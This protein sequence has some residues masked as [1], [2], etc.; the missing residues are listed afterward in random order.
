EVLP[1][2][3]HA[4]GAVRTSERLLQT[5]EI[6]DIGAN[7]F[8]ALCRQCLRGVFGGIAC[9]GAAREPS[10]GIRQ[11]CARQRATLRAGG[12]GDSNDLCV[13]HSKTSS[14]ELV[15]CE[16]S[17]VT[18]PGTGFPARRAWP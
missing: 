16:F 17:R 4:E 11:D 14:S 7:D 6:I 5:F 12:A 9:D 1:E 2:I 8:S 13:G 18:A 15:N 10:G 3:R